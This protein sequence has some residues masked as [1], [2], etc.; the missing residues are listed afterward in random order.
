MNKKKVYIY[1]HKNPG[2]DSICS[3]IACAYLKNEMV[4]KCS[5]N[6]ILYMGKVDPD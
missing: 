6:K 3:A 2:T 1:G 4:K 5:E